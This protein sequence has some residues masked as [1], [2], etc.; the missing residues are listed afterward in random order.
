[1]TTF[2]YF[3]KRV[4]KESGANNKVIKCG[5]VWLGDKLEIA[6]LKEYSNCEK[7]TAID[8]T[9]LK[10]SS[11]NL[12]INNIPFLIP[13]EE[14]MSNFLNNGIGDGSYVEEGGIVYSDTAQTNLLGFIVEIVQKNISY[15]LEK[16]NL[17]LCNEAL[18]PNYYLY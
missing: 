13:S 18:V 7:L 17:S 2:L 12:N 15:I 4:P 10:K 6:L 1:M 8:P 14:A 11:E 5:S 3:D 9:V 16:M